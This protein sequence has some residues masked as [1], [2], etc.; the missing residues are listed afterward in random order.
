MNRNTELHFTELPTINISRS[1]FE[2]NSEHKTSF[3]TGDLIPIYIDEVL[4]GDT[5]KMNLA[6]VTRMTTPIY[7]VMDNAFI[8]TF[9]FFIP[10]RLIWKHWPEFWGE[11]NSTHWEQTTEYEIPQIKAPAGGWK[12]GTLADYLG[13]PTN[14]ENIEVSHLPFRAYAK[15]VNDWFR[16]ENLK[17]PCM[18]NEDETTL[19]GKN[20][21]EGYDYVTD[22]QLGA[23]PYKAAKFGDYFTSAL[24]SAQKGPAV[25]IPVGS[26]API[27]GD[28]RKKEGASTYTI[29]T[30]LVG[31]PVSIFNYNGNTGVADTETEN[32]MQ[33]GKIIS[34][35]ADLSSATGATV[36]QLRQAFAIQKFYERQA[37]GGSRY[38]EFL[39]SHFTVTSP[40]ARLQ[41]SEYL[42][43]HRNPININQVLQTSSTDQTSPQGNTSA[44][45][46]TMINEELFTYSSTEHGYILGLACIRTN[47]TYQQGIEK[48]WSR[49]KWTDFYIPEFANLGEMP[50]LNKEIYAQGTTADEEAFAYQEA[51]ADYRYKPNRVSSA[52]R[53]NYQTSLDSWH[54]ADNYSEQPILSS[55]WIDETE[56]NVDRTLAVQSSVEDQ[57]ISDFYFQTTWVRPMPIYSVPG[58]LDHH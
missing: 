38:I 23:A 51:W 1:K 57:F 22:I 48:F 18:I 42:G 8:D 4:P 45:S 54:Y 13:I 29:D 35:T 32:G 58:L 31:K 24:P 43:G 34:L 21:G 44:F 2:R 37:R 17:D 11:N 40:D 27:I 16:D 36:N 49:K 20:K 9:F 14:V 55:E 26:T 53:S 30:N 33:Q 12:K 25:N 19:T 39:K 5:I 56:K 41:R 15:V 52:M 7:P 3:N 50:I 28:D 46:C 10:N 6:N 47:H